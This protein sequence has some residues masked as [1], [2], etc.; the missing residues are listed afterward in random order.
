MDYRSR[1]KNLKQALAEERLDALFVTHPANVQYLCGFSGSSGV[2]VAR[3]SRWAFFT[4][5][6]YTEQACQQVSGARVVTAKGSPLAAAAQW[7][8]NSSPKAAAGIEA[9]HMTVAARSALAAMLPKSVRLRETSG[10]VERLRMVKEPEEIERIRVAV[11][12]GAVLLE[13]AIEA[14]KPGVS[15]NSVA[16]EIEYAA[17]CAGAQGM[18]FP[19][20]VAAGERSALPHGLASDALIP[21]NGFIVMDFGVIL[22]DYCSDMTRT[23]HVGR[24][25]PEARAM[26]KAVLEAQLAAIAA[27]RGGVQAAE[28]DRAARLVLRRAKLDRHFTH[29]TGHGVGLEIHEPPRLGRTSDDVLLPGMVVTIEPGVYIAGLGGVRIEDMVVVTEHGCEV[30]T[31]APKELLAL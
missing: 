4:D 22:G 13:S 12:T 19:T 15:E 5:G 2:L 25:K 26:Y 21:R 11:L 3:E 14:I 6:R 16:A 30:L 23:V 27:V 31:P 10:I 7:L 20:I 29:S 24:P 8:Q 18:S 9:S 1:Q 28:V 17:R